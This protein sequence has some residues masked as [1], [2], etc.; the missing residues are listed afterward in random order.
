M[1]SENIINLT[2]CTII[3]IP[4]FMVDKFSAVKKK[5]RSHMLKRT[6]WNRLALFLIVNL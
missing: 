1:F 6:M 2:C 3:K 4:A 5:W